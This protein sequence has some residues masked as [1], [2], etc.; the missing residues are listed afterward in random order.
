MY[1]SGRELTVTVSSRRKRLNHSE[2]V[3]PSHWGQRR[4]VRELERFG[5]RFV[6][7]FVSVLQ[8]IHTFK[9]VVTKD[10]LQAIVI[11]P[12]LGGKVHGCPERDETRPRLPLPANLTVPL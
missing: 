2:G 10:E 12:D 3:V 8:E 4:R 1:Q 7:S 6:D 5:L 11:E 9:K